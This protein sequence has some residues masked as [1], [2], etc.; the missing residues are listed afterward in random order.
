MNDHIIKIVP[1]DHFVKFDGWVSAELK[2]INPVFQAA[3][4][5]PIL[6]IIQT[7]CKL[8]PQGETERGLI[9]EIIGYLYAH[10]LNVPQPQTAFLAQIPRKHIANTN[11]F[12]KDHWL[13]Q[14]NDLNLIAFC[15]ASLT[16]KTAAMSYNIQDQHHVQILLDELIHWNDC[17][18]TIALDENI[19]HVDR[20]LNNLIRLNRNSFAVIDNGILASEHSS[21]WTV[22][23]LDA[24]KRYRNRLSENIDMVN[25]D[26]SSPVKK[27]SIIASERHRVAFAQ[28]LDEMTYWTN[29]LLTEKEGKAF[30]QFLIQ[31]TENTTWIL[32]QRYEQ[33]I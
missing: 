31:R 5:H 23:E 7:H 3:I 17:P 10:A 11:K 4:R 1:V 27:R 28:V 18:N 24:D 25:S 12:G 22:S 13:N 15:T 14:N 33:L 32:T 6:G 9:N 19:A 2:N 26:Q 8:Y 30:T 21:N 16:G 20:H 29:C